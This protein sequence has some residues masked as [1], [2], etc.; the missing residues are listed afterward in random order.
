MEEKFTRA[1]RD[2]LVVTNAT[3]LDIKEDIKDLKENITGRLD[4]LEVGKAE[5]AEISDIYKTRI[6]KWNDFELRI[7]RL[8]NWRSGI[9]TMFSLVGVIIGLVTY[10]YLTEQKVIKENL[11]EI[12]LNLNKYTEQIK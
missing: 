6:P 4:K 1:D 8:E 11:T 7:K 2:M 10:I 3:V 9:I 5:E 12:K